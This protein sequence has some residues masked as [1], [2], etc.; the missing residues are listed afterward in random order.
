MTNNKLI[1]EFTTLSKNMLAQAASDRDAEVKRMLAAGASPLMVDALMDVARKE[2][3]AVLFSH[4]VEVAISSEHNDTGDGDDF[5]LHQQY[6][7]GIKQG[8]LT[9]I[10]NIFSYAEGGS[11]GSA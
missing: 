3:W 7:E 5:A 2:M 11:A 8:I 1:S 9:C 10:S 6:A 4:L